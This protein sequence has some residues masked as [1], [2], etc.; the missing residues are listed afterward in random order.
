MFWKRRRPVHIPAGPRK[1]RE[2]WP[3]PSEVIYDFVDLEP[4]VHDPQTCPL[5]RCSQRVKLKDKI[6]MKNVRG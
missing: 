4:H 3:P 2:P 6:K 5:R 1:A